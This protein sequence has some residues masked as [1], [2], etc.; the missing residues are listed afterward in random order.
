MKK[1]F[2][3][4]ICFLLVLS[5]SLTATA[6]NFFTLNPSLF[7]GKNS[8]DFSTLSGDRYSL[9]FSQSNGEIG[10][11]LPFEPIQNFSGSALVSFSLSFNSETTDLSSII[12][13]SVTTN[14]VDD[15]NI[16][17]Q[18]NIV[19]GNN[20]VAV[21]NLGAN[22]LY[23]THSSSSTNGASTLNHST[24]NFYIVY[25]NIPS[26]QFNYYIKCS[27][28][29]SLSS[30]FVET[31]EPVILLVDGT[32]EEVSSS[33]GSIATSASSLDQGMKTLINKT[34]TTSSSEI[35]AMRDVQAAIDDFKN[36]YTQLQSQADQSTLESLKQEVADKS[37]EIV[38]SVTEKIS[39]DYSDIET[40]FYSLFSALSNHSDNPTLTLPAGSVTIAGTSYTFWDE[41]TVS[42]NAVLQHDIVKMLLYPIRLIVYVGFAFY[43][44]DFITKLE[45]LITM[46]RS[47]V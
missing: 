23:F 19:Y 35:A 20:R 25:S 32:S 45:S 46:N 29:S 8:F 30:A 6:E 16:G 33:V 11:L 10:I 39:I 40:G 4:L 2:C 41:Q 15:S 26:S 34:L 27:V 14:Y 22:K 38:N 13:T 43:C 44:L 1:A 31:S 18:Y 12:Q 47:D 3:L 28:P 5:I 42:L 24:L 7:I 17:R 37:N 21:T 9:D 36:S